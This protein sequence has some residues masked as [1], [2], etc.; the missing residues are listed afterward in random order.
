MKSKALQEYTSSENSQT[1][2]PFRPLSAQNSGMKQKGKPKQKGKTASYYPK[3][4]NKLKAP[5]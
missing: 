5:M 2:S 4:C 3:K 1:G